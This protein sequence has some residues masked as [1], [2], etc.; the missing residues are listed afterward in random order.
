MPEKMHPT[1]TPP[2]QGQGDNID[3]VA[4]ATAYGHLG[5]RG[6]FCVDCLCQVAPAET[7]WSSTDKLRAFIDADKG[8]V[9]K[10]DESGFYPLQWAALNNRVA[11]ANLLLSCGADVNATDHTGQTPLHWATVRGSL[12]V[13]E[14]LLRHGANHEA[15]DNR[16]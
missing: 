7:P 4:R 12:P 1:Q 13:L 5:V 8:C 15:R 10:A 16:G 6:L 9:S 14:T 3:T 2:Q 11:E